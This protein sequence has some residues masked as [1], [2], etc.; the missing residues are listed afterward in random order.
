[1]NSLNDICYE[2]IKDNYYYGLFGDF[3][4]IIDKETGYFN[5]TKLCKDGGK[6]FRNW[7]QNKNS[8]ELVKYYENRPSL[9]SSGVKSIIKISKNE[10]NIDN[11]IIS[12]CYVRKEL[13]LSISL[14]IS[15][16]FYDKVYKIIESYFINEFNENYKKDMNKLKKKLDVVLVETEKLR[17]KNQEYKDD[18]APKTTQ[19]RRL[20]MFV[21]IQKNEEDKYPYYAIRCQRVIYNKTLKDLKI[22]YPNLTVVIEIP[23]NP[24]TINLFNRMKENIT[25]I[26]TH[27]NHLKLKEYNIERFKNDIIQLI[28]KLA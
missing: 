3:K 25:Y 6:R 18:V 10:D 1:M 16:D 17:I 7:L 23:Y 22:R 11:K 5:A 9:N 20:N 24:N 15:N 28:P 26:D 13:I 19:P 12:G 27:F 2:Q 21:V 8:Q 4:L 14:W